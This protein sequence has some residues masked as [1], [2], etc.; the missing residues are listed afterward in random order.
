MVASPA[1][2]EPFGAVRPITLTQA[3]PLPALS[4]WTPKSALDADTQA[5]R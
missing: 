3:S 5:K 1:D 2:W 4:M